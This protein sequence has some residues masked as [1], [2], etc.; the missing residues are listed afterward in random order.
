M[1]VRIMSAIVGLALLAVVLLFFN[2]IVL[3]IALM[4]IGMIAVWELLHATGV[5]HNPFLTVLGLAVAAVIPFIPYDQ[6]SKY[7]TFYA[8]PYMGVLFVILLLTHRAT[9][10]EHIAMT[11]VFSMAVPFAFSTAVYLRDIHGWLGGFFYILLALGGGWLSDT[12]AYFTGNLFGKHKLAPEISPKKTIEGA[13]GG[14]VTCALG[15]LLIAYLFQ[16]GCAFYQMSLEVNY[17][18]VLILAPVASVSG[19]IGDLAASIIKRQYGIKDFGH[20]MPGHGGVMDRFDSVL[21][22]L[23]LVYLLSLTI[24][25]LSF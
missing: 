24:P 9:R 11:A 20:I 12:G 13:V 25:N 4:L 15:Y 3:N 10:V 7:L 18:Y 21:F 19:I 23:P 5:T 14:V 16:K 22:V 8:L 2:T 17:L 1:K 6:V